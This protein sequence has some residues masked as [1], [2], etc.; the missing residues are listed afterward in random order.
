MARKMKKTTDVK[1]SG[2]MRRV[3]RV[4]R[5]VAGTAERPRVCVTKTNRRMVAQVIND[6]LGKTLLSMTSADNKTANITLAT[7]LGKTL[8]KKAMDMGIKAV[9]F[10]RGGR[11]FHGRVAAVAT[12][13][14]EGGLKL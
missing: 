6:E 7:E 11:V 4:R 10:D 8:A 3:K 13:L 14:R 12:G 9:V 5:K 2:R 1:L